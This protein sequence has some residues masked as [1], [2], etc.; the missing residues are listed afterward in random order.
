M[1]TE[2][3]SWVLL[4]CQV[5]TGMMVATTTMKT[6]SVSWVLLVCVR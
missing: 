2:S 4:V 1:K 5:T 6:E 3:V